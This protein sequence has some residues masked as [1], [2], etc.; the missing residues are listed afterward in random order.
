MTTLAGDTG[1]S[2]ADASA[3]KPRSIRPGVPVSDRVFRAIARGGGILMLVIML[4]IAGFLGQQ[5]APALG[6]FGWHFFTVQTWE[7]EHLGV[8]GVITGTLLVAVVAIVVSFPLAMFTALYIAEYS[9][10]WL[11]RTLIAVLDLMAA[12]P[13]VVYGLWGFAVLQNNTIYLSRWLHTYLGFLPFFHVDTDPHAAL[14]DKSMYT[15]SIFISGLVVSLMVIPI[16]CSVM[17][18][19]F[20]QAP[21][22]EREAALAL[23]GTRW[24]MVRA[25]VLPFGRGGIIGGT[26]LGLG[27]ALGETIAITY[28]LSPDFSVHFR[29]LEKGGSTIS[30]LIANRFGDATG[31]QVSALLAA[32]LTLFAITL[33]VNMI[34]GF[35]VARS[36]SGAATEI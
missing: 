6:V 34:A 28:I 13:S 14:W 2:G 1:S 36:R 24:G 25:V 7:G 27:R 20:S 22:G 29:I 21:Q 8:L 19:V 9:P 26:M 11:R 32:G 30:S 33:V 17:R 18:E 35:V 16:A 4:G 3:D 23:G 10:R 12:V 15:S 5:A 31:V